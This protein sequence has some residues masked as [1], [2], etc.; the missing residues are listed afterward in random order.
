MNNLKFRVWD[1]SNNRFFSQEVLDILPL[2]IFLASE[3]IQQ[4]TGL[5]DSKGKEIYE[6][7]ILKVWMGGDLQDG[8]YIVEDLCEFYLDCNCDD[9]CIRI[10]QCEIVGNI[11]ENPTY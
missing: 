1:N 7:D 9:S 3:N 4:F 5:K 6:K 10:T 11:F 2:K 8:H